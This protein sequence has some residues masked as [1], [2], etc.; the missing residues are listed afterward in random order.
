M[1]HQKRNEEN[2]WLKDCETEVMTYEYYKEIN[3]NCEN[4]RAIAGKGANTLNF[5]KLSQ[6]HWESEQKGNIV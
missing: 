2:D 5:D 3:K 4:F 6:L 1:E